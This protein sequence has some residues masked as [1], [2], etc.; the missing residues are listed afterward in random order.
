MNEPTF[1]DTPG[2]EHHFFQ[3]YA[4]EHQKIRV[5]MIPTVVVV[6]GVAS[7]FEFILDSCRQ[8]VGSADLMLHTGMTQ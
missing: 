7:R 2:K 6:L 3:P 8:G 1:V 5:V 4:H